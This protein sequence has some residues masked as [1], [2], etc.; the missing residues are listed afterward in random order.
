M[1][2]LDSRQ[3]LCPQINFLSV[4]ENNV[5]NVLIGTPRSVVGIH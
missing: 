1:V 3:P 4:N 5:A 2:L